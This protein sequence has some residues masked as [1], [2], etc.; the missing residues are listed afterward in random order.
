MSS[1]R[2]SK[3]LQRK[4]QQLDLPMIGNVLFFSHLAYFSLYLKFIVVSNILLGTWQFVGISLEKSRE[5]PSVTFWGSDNFHANGSSNWLQTWLSHSL[6][7]YLGVII[8]CPCSGALI[9]LTSYL[10]VTF[11]MGLS[12]A[13]YL[14]R[15]FWCLVCTYRLTWWQAVVLGIR[16]LDYQLGTLKL[17]F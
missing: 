11:I 3:L 16:G 9:K 1:F 2:G 10:V 4:N 7:A 12:W 17:L 8:F 13:D 6:W 14:L 15:L 5:R